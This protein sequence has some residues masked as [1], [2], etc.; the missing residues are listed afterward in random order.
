MAIKLLMEEADRVGR[1]V[2]QSEAESLV[3]V[4]DGHPLAIRLAARAL[5]GQ[6][7]AELLARFNEIASGLY[8]IEGRELPS[9]D[10]NDGAAQLS[11]TGIAIPTPDEV[12]AIQEG[13]PLINVIVQSNQQLLKRIADDP[14][15]L[16]EVSSRQFEEIVAE[17]LRHRGF[18]VRLT[19]A[20]RDGGKDIYAAAN[21]GLGSFLYI[22]ECKKYGP[23]QKVGVGVV[24]QLYGVVEAE[25]ATAGI[26]VTTAYFT[27]VAKAF[28]ERLAYR[29]SLKDYSA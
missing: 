13:A 7:V 24:R 20:S 2:T 29:V 19:A 25:Q 8:D 1:V 12:A 23:D 16:Y 6:T 21:D 11:E 18:D 4:L 9:I 26:I 28:E 5:I 17:L 10:A 22:V 14:R 15:L 3:S 27:S